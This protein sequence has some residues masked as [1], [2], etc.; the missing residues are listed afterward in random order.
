MATGASRRRPWCGDMPARSSKDAAVA[1]KR[2]TALASRRY[3][4]TEMQEREKEG[5]QSEAGR[6]EP[7][8]GGASADV[9]AV[10]LHVH[11]S[12]ILEWRRC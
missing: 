8:L 7:E 3:G 9:A 11:A 2:V 4:K 6:V 5:A 1:S 10:A 12:F